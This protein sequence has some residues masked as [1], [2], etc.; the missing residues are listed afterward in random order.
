MQ[1]GPAFVDKLDLIEAP[2][3]AALFCFAP[4][5]ARCLWREY[6]R[7][8]DGQGAGARRSPVLIHVKVGH[9]RIDTFKDMLGIAASQHATV[10]QAQ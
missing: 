2:C 7:T 9:W 1:A 6:F 5:R 3:G 10:R 8:K 4:W